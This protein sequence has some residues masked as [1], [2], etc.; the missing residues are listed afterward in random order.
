MSS[1]FNESSFEKYLFLITP[2]EL[3]RV[4][5]GL[6]HVVS[7]TGVDLDYTESDPDV[8]LQKY[9]ELYRRLS[10]GDR[11]IWEQDYPLVGA[12]TGLTAHLEN[13]TYTPHTLRRIPDFLEPCVNLEPFCFEL[14]PSGQLSTSF[15]CGHFPE[16]VCG[17]MLYFPRKIEYIKPTERH[18]EGF[19][20]REEMADF[21][22]FQR[23][24][25]QIGAITKPLRLKIFEKTYRTA[26][27]VSPKAKT[28]LQNFWFVKRNCAEI[29]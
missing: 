21:A 26:V 19:A 17:L 8:F 9:A 27:R 18:E 16:K 11:L 7:C 4:L 15:Y 22:T 14:M 2:E 20:N 28:D 1:Y 6:H 24:K 13:C 12:Q 10:A 23:L 29:L 5:A 3:C 25:E